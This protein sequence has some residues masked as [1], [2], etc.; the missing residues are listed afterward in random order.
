MTPRGSIRPRTRCSYQSNHVSSPE[1]PSDIT[2]HHIGVTHLRIGTTAGVQT[3]VSEGISASSPSLVSRRSD[4]LGHRL[5]RASRSHTDRGDQQAGSGGRKA[6]LE[7]SAAAADEPPRGL[8]P[9]LLSLCRFLLCLQLSAK[10][11]FENFT[12]RFCSCRDCRHIPEVP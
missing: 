1:S 7:I 9:P 10:T 5:R 4:W 12:G 2:D 8:L 6:P 11:N 3:Q